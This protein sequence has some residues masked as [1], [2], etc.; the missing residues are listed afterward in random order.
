MGAAPF[1]VWLLCVY[2]DNTVVNSYSC[3][4]Q[5]FLRTYQVLLIP[6]SKRGCFIAMA[7]RICVKQ[8]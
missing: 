5:Q 4:R 2:K 3:L 8:D 1:G 7:T 6:V